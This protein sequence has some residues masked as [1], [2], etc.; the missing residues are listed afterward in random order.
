[1]HIWQ[2][3]NEQ[4]NLPVQIPV[5]YDN[6]EFQKK[7]NPTIFK[8]VLLTHILYFWKIKKKIII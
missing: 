2:K 1:M 3:K 4:K 6:I 8:K 7:K 5:G